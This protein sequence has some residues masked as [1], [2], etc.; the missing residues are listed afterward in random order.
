MGIA[1]LVALLPVIVVAAISVVLMLVTSFLRHQRLTSLIT[2]GGFVLAALLV[3]GDLG[4]AAVQVTPLIIIDDYS[5][6]FSLVLLL[7]SL[8]A[9]MLAYDYLR[10]SDVLKEEFYILLSLAVLGAIVLVS[11][12]HFAAFFIGIELMSVSLFAMV[13]YMVQGQTRRSANLEASIKYMILSGVSSSF[14][15]FGIA[16]VYADFGVLSFDGLQA[17]F[18]LQNTSAYSQIG[19][20]MILVGMAFKLSWVPFHMWTPDVYEGAPVPVTAFLATVSKASVFAIIVR[21]FI[22]TGALR[23]EG[24]MQALA[25]I[26]LLS[27]L[28]GNGL[29]LLQRNVKRLLAYSSIAHLGYLLVAF[30]AMSALEIS[31]Q[32]LAVEA[33]AFYL[34]AYVVMSLIAFGVITTLSSPEQALEAETIENFRGLF[35]RQPWLATAM[36][37]ALLSLAGIPLTI[38]FVGKF[39]VFAAGVAEQL[40]LLVSILIVGSALG[41]YYYLRIIIEMCKSTSG[42]DTAEPPFVA[43]ESGLVLSLLGLVLLVIGIFPAGLMVAVQQAVAAL[44]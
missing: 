33:T 22:E 13:G 14:L 35:W 15:L 18:A 1:E 12:N 19:T 39:Y 3:A 41:L 32:Q 37:L 25:A 36:S 27:M 17:R 7:T 24:L 28:A 31:S 40:W 10:R 4:E 23:F 5:R 44:H 21:F 16:L 43:A 26:A 38:G 42:T 6:F 2:C 11:S 34:V 29:A 9:T 20:A 8:A 30:V